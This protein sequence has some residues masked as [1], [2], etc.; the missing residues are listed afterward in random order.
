MGRN[1]HKAD[2]YQW[3]G[4]AGSRDLI[5]CRDAD[6]TLF[7]VYDEGLRTNMLN[8]YMAGLEAGKRTGRIKLQYELASLLGVEIKK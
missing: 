7:A 3:E 2:D 8:A 4:S 5:V 1:F 6:T